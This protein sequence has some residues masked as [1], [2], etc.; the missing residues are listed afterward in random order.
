MHA[1]VIICAALAFN[2]LG[3]M[4]KRKGEYIGKGTMAL[5]YAWKKSVMVPYARYA[6][7]WRVAPTRSDLVCAHRTLPFWTILRIRRKK[8]VAY[9]VVLDRGPYGYCARRSR[10]DKRKGWLNGRFDQR[11]PK[12]H[13]YQVIVKRWKRKRTPGY[14][15]AMLDATPAVHRLLGTRKSGWVTVRV[16]KVGK[17]RLRRVLRLMR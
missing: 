11:C 1:F 2:P 5:Y 4:Y 7:N 17:E 16:E 9:C 6:G 10:H 13:R 15:R 14:Y 3:S 12:T 8:R